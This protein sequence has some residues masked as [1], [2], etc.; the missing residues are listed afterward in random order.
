MTSSL[1][2][3]VRPL[4]ST[5][6]AKRLLASKVGYPSGPPPPSAACT[7]SLCCTTGPLVAYASPEATEVLTAPAVGQ[8][9]GQKEDL[10]ARAPLVCYAV[11]YP[12]GERRHGLRG[13]GSALVAPH[14][15]AEP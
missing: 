12:T 14:H 10:R 7:V 6:C 5:R 1:Q 13:R 4:R 9:E 8:V 15:H 2:T 3:P 11:V